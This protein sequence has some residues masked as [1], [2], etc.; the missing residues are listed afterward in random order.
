MELRSSSC[1]RA[2]Q[3]GLRTQDENRRALE[4]MGGVR[5]RDLCNT[6]HS[7]RKP[8]PEWT[9]KNLSQ[10]FPCLT[11]TGAGPSLYFSAGSAESR[12]IDPWEIMVPGAPSAIGRRW[13]VD[14]LPLGVAQ[15]WCVASVVPGC[16]S[17]VVQIPGMGSRLGQA[18]PA[19]PKKN[20][21]EPTRLCGQRNPVPDGY[22]LRPLAISWDAACVLWPAAHAPQP[23]ASPLSHGAL[24]ISSNPMP[25]APMARCL[26]P[27][28]VPS[29]TTT[30]EAHYFVTLKTF[31]V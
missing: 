7:V 6:G 13:Q 4:G 21:C 29:W 20:G 12:S 25:L 24:P 30:A 26:C 16:W 11:Q 23:G 17:E 19:Q 10:T 2:R 15:V 8:T 31:V 9:E 14:T 18:S 1:S 28:D 22:V 27:F 3:R 5:S